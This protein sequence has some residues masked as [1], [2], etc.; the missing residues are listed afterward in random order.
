LIDSGSNRRISLLASA[1]SR[2]SRRHQAAIIVMENDAPKPPGNQTTLITINVDGV[3]REIFSVEEKAADGKLILKFDGRGAH[4]DATTYKGA[5]VEDAIKEH[6]ISIH[7]SLESKTEINAIHRTMLLQNGRKLE[8]RHYTNAVKTTKQFATVFFERCQDFRRAPPASNTQSDAQ[9][10]LGWYD[11]RQFQLV[12][13]IVVGSAEREFIPTTVP[14]FQQFN[15]SQKIFGVF[16]LVIIWSFISLPSNPTS[17]YSVVRTHKPEVIPT[18]EDPRLQE[19]LQMTADGYDEE[20]S[21]IWFYLQRQNLLNQYLQN[22][23]ND[24]STADE[25]VLR[26]MNARAAFF[27]NG[28]P[29]STEFRELCGKA[30]DVFTEDEMDRLKKHFGIADVN[31]NRS[32]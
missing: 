5:S 26:L 32:G 8:T 3:P 2:F 31:L 1:K 15:I 17:N 13:G 6:H 24:N 23:K 30:R 20:G 7:R 27:K 4:T 22:L 19:F 9:I 12:Y 10:S 14:D 21:L 25:V 16:R 18:L 11:P 29:G 28:D